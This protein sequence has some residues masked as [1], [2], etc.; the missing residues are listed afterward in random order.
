MFTGIVEE[1][2]VVAGL[3]HKKNLLILSVR[4]HKTAQRTKIGDS[5]AVDGVCLT[6]C[7]RR[8]R[9]LDFDVMKETIDKTTLKYL[10]TGSRVN[11][12][13]ALRYNGRVGGHFVLGHVEGVGIIEKKIT[14]PNYVQYNIKI[15]KKLAFYLVSK[16]C[17]CLDGISLTVGWVRGNI[18]SVYIIPHT[19][20]VT[21]LGDKKP[22]DKVNI[23]TDILTK[24]ILK[25]K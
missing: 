6:V 15:E 20:K 11:L 3:A 1:K 21:T 23:E 12:E 5:L 2:G 22:S 18:F 7:H 8:G 9:V 19:L 10:K 4:T 13:R 16:G 17:V 24:Y 14:I 25:Q